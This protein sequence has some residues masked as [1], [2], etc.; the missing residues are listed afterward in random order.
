MFK[1][2]YTIVVKWKEINV[3]ALMISNIIII[4]VVESKD[5]VDYYSL[6]H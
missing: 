1:G 3:S 6:T 4:E 5:F 2:N